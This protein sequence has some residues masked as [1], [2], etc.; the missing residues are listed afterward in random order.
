MAKKLPDSNEQ[1]HH[2]RAFEV[3][4]SLGPNR[5]YRQV[6]EQIGVSLRTIKNWARAFSWRTRV[7][8]RDSEVARRLADQSLDQSVEETERHLKIVNAALIRWVRDLADGK[9][10]MQSGDLDRLIRLQEHLRGVS[11]GPT[12]GGGGGARR[13]DIIIYL[14]DNGRGDCPGRILSR[15]ESGIDDGGQEQESRE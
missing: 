15:E 4:N 13:A 10:R 2:R 14:P 11:T 3:Y 1:D 8:E 6:A 9:I 5:T 12:D 7:A